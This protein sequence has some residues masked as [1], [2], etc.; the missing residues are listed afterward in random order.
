MHIIDALE[1]NEDDL[2]CALYEAPN[3]NAAKAVFTTFSIS[4]LSGPAQ[5]IFSFWKANDNFNWLFKIGNFFLPTADC[6]ECVETPSEVRDTFTDDDGVSLLV[7]V[8]EVG[9]P[10]LGQIGTWTIQDNQADT[11]SVSGARGPVPSTK[12]VTLRVTMRA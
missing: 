6:S 7:H 9:G 1:A 2:I 3:V 10:W 11:T 8:P 5:Y 12:A 4:F